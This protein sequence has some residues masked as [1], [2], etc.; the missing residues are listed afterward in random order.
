MTETQMIHGY[1]LSGEALTRLFEN[2]DTEQFLASNKENF[3]R[4][5]KA[6]EETEKKMGPLEEG[7]G[8]YR[9]TTP[10]EYMECLAC[11]P[12]YPAYPFIRLVCTED[13]QA[14]L[15]PDFNLAQMS[16][17]EQDLVMR[18]LASGAKEVDAQGMLAETIKTIVGEGLSYDSIAQFVSENA[19]R[20]S[21]PFDEDMDAVYRETEKQMQAKVNEMY[22][23]YKTPDGDNVIPFPGSR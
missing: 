17:K 20:V 8:D 11:T 4:I 15:L 9:V 10:G 21:M 5:E 19:V 13:E 18:F 6:F 23:G 2:L 16:D 14:I 7:E 1:G 12:F 3:D 22:R